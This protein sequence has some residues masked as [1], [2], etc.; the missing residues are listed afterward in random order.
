MNTADRSIAMLDTALRRRF[1]FIEMLPNPQLFRGISVEGV[2]IAALLTILNKR[3]EIL[4]DRDHT[5]GHAYFMPL[6]SRP[7]LGVLAHIFKN[8]IIPLLQEYFYDDYEKMR[9]VLGDNKKAP[10]EQFIVT[11]DI[12]YDAIFGGVKDLYLEN[13]EIYTVNSAAF[14]NINSYL[15]IF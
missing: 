15:K 7:N 6:R 3:V 2:D 1:D 14:S 10:E 12:D 13:D 8:A 5:I 11:Q 4:L 9:L